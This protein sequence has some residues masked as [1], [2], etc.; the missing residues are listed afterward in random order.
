M[1]RDLDFYKILGVPPNASFDEIRAAYRKLAR[2]YHP[3]LNPGNPQAEDTFKLIN[4]AYEVL[5]DPEQRKKFD[6]LRTYGVSF[7]NPF[8]RNPTEIELE[9]LMSV[10]LKELDKLFNEWIKRIQQ[11]IN[12]L[13]KTPFRLIDM[14]IKAIG[15]LIPSG[16]SE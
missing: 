11:R 9:E 13:I 7:Q 6:F 12:S 14:A 1:T 8:S 15:K 5:K 2:Q 4:V 3:D 10:Y 16:K